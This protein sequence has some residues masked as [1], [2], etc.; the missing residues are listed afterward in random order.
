MKTLL[1]VWNELAQARSD[2]R[3]GKLKVSEVKELN[4][5]AGKCIDI[6]KVHNEFAVVA[7]CPPTSEFLSPT[8][9]ELAQKEI[10]KKEAAGRQKKQRS[11][12]QP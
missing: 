8:A 1:D 9:Q 5:S 7:G 11:N 12:K 2:L 10:L 4:N 3:A 6:A